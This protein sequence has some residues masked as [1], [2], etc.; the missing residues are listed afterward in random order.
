MSTPQAI[1]IVGGLVNI[2]ISSVAGYILL[3]VRMRD[4]AKPISRYA[5]T[6]HTSAI[7]HGL[8]LLGLSLAI[9]HTGYIPAISIGIAVAEVVATLFANMRNILSWRSNFDDAISEGTVTDNRL[10]ALVN[11]I[12]LFDSVALL[13]GVTRTALAI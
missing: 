10:R 4:P 1:L 8:L 5:I 2:V 13:Y 11:A 9:P 6:T 3:W 7:T 12:H